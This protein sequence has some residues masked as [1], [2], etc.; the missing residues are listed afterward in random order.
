MS[1]VKKIKVSNHKW[2]EIFVTSYPVL[3]NL[4]KLGSNICIQNICNNDFWMHV[5]KAYASF[6]QNV[7]IEKKKTFL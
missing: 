3:N 5:F 1:W 6:G 7:R 4:E 2:K